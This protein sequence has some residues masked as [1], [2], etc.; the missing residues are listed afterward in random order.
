MIGLFIVSSTVGR[1][2]EIGKQVKEKV[3]DIFENV[4]NLKVFDLIT[5]IEDAEKAIKRTT[6]KISGCIIVVATGGTER[7]IRNISTKIKRPVFLWANPSN[8]SLASSLEA[9]SKLRENIP[10]KLFY[11]PLNAEQLAEVKSFIEVCEAINKL[12]NCRLGCIGEP[13]K[14]IL[15]SSTKKIIKQFGPK[16]IKLKLQDLIDAV[17]K[18]NIDRA[19]NLSK[20]L[21]KNFRRIEV[22][23]NDMINATKVYLAMKELIS[24]HDLSAITI[25]CFD[26]LSYGCTA[27]LGM[28]LCNDE[29]LVAGCEADL[30]TTITMMVVSFLANQPCWMAN[31]SMIDKDKNTITLAHCTIPTKMIDLSKAALLPHMESGKCVSV[32]GPL[33][34][35]EV[36]LVRLGGNLDKMLIATGR[37]VRS[38]MKLPNLCR[39]QVEVK[40]K[41]NVEDWLVNTL[42]NHQV[43]VYGN[44]ESKLLDFCKFKG[45]K[46]ILIK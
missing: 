8:N 19:K 1:Q 3:S 18:I 2:K 39:T 45:I 30:Q 11:S 44:L 26:L 24:K 28:S 32:R 10:M 40:L 42:G 5:T 25:R 20:K 27:C 31:T 6:D 15:T 9:F 35:S 13:S 4:Q 34:N 41:G 36:T 17:E 23:E 46:P 22:S 12:G 16:M 14:W 33:K 21:M 43:L 29:G 38:D 37:V 7:I